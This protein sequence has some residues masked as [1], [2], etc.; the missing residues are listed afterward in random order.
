ME[1]SK[2][3][4][5]DFRTPAY[6]DGLTTK[7]QKLLKKAGIEQLDM[8]GKFVAIKMHFGQFELP[9]PELCQGSG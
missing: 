7:L 1:K 3:F 4:F 9:S 6:G 8:D 2:V 5:T